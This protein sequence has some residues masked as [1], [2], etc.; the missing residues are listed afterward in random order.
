MSY[1]SYVWK[2]L[3]QSLRAFR[4]LKDL[5]ETRQGGFLYAFVCVIEQEKHFLDVIE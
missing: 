3:N 4:V 5:L 1:L 2:L